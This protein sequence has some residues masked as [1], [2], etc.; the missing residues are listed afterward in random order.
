MNKAHR[1]K[2]I[3]IMREH[4]SKVLRST[5]LASGAG[6]VLVGL[7]AV[8]MPEAYVAMVNFGFSIKY[9]PEEITTLGIILTAVG[10]TDIIIASI[11]FKDRKT[12]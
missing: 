9:G 12:L 5:L 2:Q 4:Q 10:L 1:E 11:I 3:K 7:S 8:F 6:M